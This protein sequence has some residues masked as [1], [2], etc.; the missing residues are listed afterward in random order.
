MSS[1]DELFTRVR[2]EN[3]AALVGYLPAGF[4]TVE[5]TI[6]AIA[7]MIDGGGSEAIMFGPCDANRLF[8]SATESPWVASLPNW[9][10]TASAGWLNQGPSAVMGACVDVDFWTSTMRQPS[11]D[12]VIHAASPRGR[13]GAPGCEGRPIESRLDHVDG[14][15]LPG[16]GPRIVANFGWASPRGRPSLSARLA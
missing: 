16:S 9:V 11:H 13:Q 8:A 12:S 7:A 15:D 2:A 3:R 5:G 6:K 10:T 14:G 4:P 1:I